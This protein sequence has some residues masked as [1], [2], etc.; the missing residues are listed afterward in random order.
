MLV[1]TLWVATPF[2]NLYLKK[3][4]Q[5]HS[6]SFFIFLIIFFFIFKLIFSEMKIL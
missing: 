6:F 2:T 4:K 3:K 1:L 5:K